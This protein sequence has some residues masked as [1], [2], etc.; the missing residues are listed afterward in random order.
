MVK[1]QQIFAE[2]PDG[3]DENWRHA[4]LLG[5][6]AHSIDMQKLTGKQLTYPKQRVL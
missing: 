1:A 6:I 5:G 4:A 2:V 3:I